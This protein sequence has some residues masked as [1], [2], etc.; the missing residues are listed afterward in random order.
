MDIK[1]SRISS[2]RLVAFGVTNR[3]P[4]H[5]ISSNMKDQ[6]TENSIHRGSLSLQGVKMIKARVIKAKVIKA[7]VIKA[8][9]IKA[10]MIK[11]K[12]W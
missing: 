6:Y 1:F 12:V 9:V 7:R 5:K 4:V 3:L 11:A 8:K 2:I 10:E